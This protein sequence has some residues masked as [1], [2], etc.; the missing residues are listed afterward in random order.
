MAC[1]GGHGEALIRLLF[2]ERPIAQLLGMLSASFESYLNCFNCKSCIHHIRINSSGDSL[3][4]MTECTKDIKSQ[5]VSCPRTLIR[6]HFRVSH[7]FAQGFGGLNLSL[8]YLWPILISF[9][10][11]HTYGF[12]INIW[13]TILHFH[14]CF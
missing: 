10:H 14:I 5:S 9:S 6:I 3:N 8:T 13:H 7:E 4:L 2:K 1:C 12:L 11:F